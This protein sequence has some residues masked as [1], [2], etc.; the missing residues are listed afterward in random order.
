MDAARLASRLYSS[1]PLGEGEKPPK[2]YVL[3]EFR[4]KRHGRMGAETFPN[5][6]TAQCPEGE[7]LKSVAGLKH[8]RSESANG[9]LVPLTASV[10]TLRVGAR[11]PW[12]SHA[13]PL[14]G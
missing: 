11:G 10:E 8:A 5:L 2:P 6:C 3:T 13:Q 9:P 7:K 12:Q 1:G 4:T 14:V